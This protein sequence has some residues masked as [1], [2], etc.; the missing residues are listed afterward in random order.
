MRAM[1]RSCT[2]TG[3]PNEAPLHAVAEQHDVTITAGD[4][5]PRATELVCV[6]D[7]S[8]SMASMLDDAQG[9]LDAFL[10][11]QRALALPC[12]LTLHS[13]DTIYE[14]PIP[15]TP[16]H[17][18]RRYV[19]EP[20]GGTALWD[21]VARTIRDLDAIYSA[22]GRLDA[23]K[24][25]P[26]IIV[27]IVTDGQENSSREFTRQTVRRMVTEKQEAGWSFVFVGVGIDAYA[28]GT[29]AMGTNAYSTVSTHTAS[30]GYA[31]ADSAI[32]RARL[33]GASVNFTKRERDEA[34]E[35]VSSP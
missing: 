33:T 30:A 22:G 5:A 19:I 26:Q 9:G 21:A 27:L 31:V 8:G 29:L 4:A 24:W 16:I 25:S 18:A 20:R 2:W 10:A 14:T 11:G 15:R 13:F 12:N 3:Q 17:A 23:T 28:E 7:R 34:E 1:C 6:I 32:S 35:P